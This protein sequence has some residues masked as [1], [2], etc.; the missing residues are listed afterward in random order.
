MKILAFFVNRWYTRMDS[1]C[2]DLNAEIYSERRKQMKNKGIAKVSQMM[3]LLVMAAVILIGAIPVTTVQASSYK[4][5]GIEL[6]EDLKPNFMDY[7][8]ES[9]MFKLPETIRDDQEISV[10]VTTDIIDVMAAY[11]ATDKS[12]SFTDYALYSD[13]AAAIQEQVAQRKSAILAAL[14]EQGVAYS[15]GKDYATVLTGFELIIQASDYAATCKALGQG[16]RAIIGEVDK[17]AETKLVENTVNI[18]TE[19]GI[20]NSSS[21]AYDGSGMTVATGKS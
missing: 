10:I 21:V 5:S 14:D 18:F 2:T 1:V 7:I 20:F 8:D 16:E 19:T 15:T 4:R 17:K 13:E 3:L 6:R 9:V 11:E 12:M